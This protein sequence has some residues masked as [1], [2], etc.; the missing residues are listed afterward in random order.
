MD[1]NLDLRTGELR[2]EGEGLTLTGVVA[3]YGV[4]T[5]IAGLFRERI[6]AGAFGPL[7]GLDVI[8]DRQH[9]R[10]LTLART[11]GGGIELAD[12]PDGLTM[13]AQLA[14]TPLARETVTLVRDGVLRGLSV[15]LN[16]ARER[17]QGD[18]RIVQR[19]VLSRFSVVDSGAYSGAVVSA[20]ALDMLANGD[21]DALASARGKLWL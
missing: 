19:A 20:R 14:D 3:P 9:E 16:V 7:A 1:D 6:D 15:V 8:M 13:R 2:A 10:H 12:T 17:W 11:G 4:E 18:L 5:N 21:R